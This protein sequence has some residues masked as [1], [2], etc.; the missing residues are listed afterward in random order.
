MKN[1]VGIEAKSGKLLWKSEWPG[2]V[3][4]IPT[5]IYADN[6]VYISSGY[7][8]GC[9]LVELGGFSP[10]DIY[11]NKV[12]KNHHGGVIKK[13]IFYTA[14]RTVMDG[15]AKISKAANWYGMKR[16][17]LEKEQLLMQMANSIVWAKETVG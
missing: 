1:L 16:R 10:K 9:K 17:L 15:F 12:M 7:G 6:H 13:G 11:E 8:V 14:I 5:P 4:V 2:K 3:A